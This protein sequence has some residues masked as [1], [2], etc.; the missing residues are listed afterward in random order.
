MITL[1]ESLISNIKKGNDVGAIKKSLDDPELIKQLVRQCT[2]FD[3]NKPEPQIMVGKNNGFIRYVYNSKNKWYHISIDMDKWSQFGLPKDIHFSTKKTKTVI[4]GGMYLYIGLTSKK[5]KNI[6]GFSF[7]IGERYNNI[8]KIIIENGTKIT[9]CIFNSETIFN[10]VKEI[11]MS[12]IHQLNNGRTV[13]NW[14]E[15]IGNGSDKITYDIKW[16]QMLP[17]ESIPV[18]GSGKNEFKYPDASWMYVDCLYDFVLNRE[19]KEAMREL[20]EDKY[21]NDSKLKTFP[22]RLLLVRF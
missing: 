20:I 16:S 22:I 11:D 14:I 6:D 12:N 4:D 3:N 7:S 1:R 21:N 17:E 10:V 18:V 5:N 8:S 15:E 13:K 2:I 9:N 19:E